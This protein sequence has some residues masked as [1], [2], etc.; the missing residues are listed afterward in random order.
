MLGNVYK[1]KNIQAEIDGT[2]LLI[3]VWWGNSGQ[4]FSFQS[5][6]TD[7]ALLNLVYQLLLYIWISNLYLATPWF[8][9][10]SRVW[11]NGFLK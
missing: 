9:M 5:L 11:N 7:L 1:V 3:R 10:L 8:S 6:F 2:H 4:N